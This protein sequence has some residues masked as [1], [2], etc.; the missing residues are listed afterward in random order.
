MFSRHRSQGASLNKVEFN[1]PV[2]LPLLLLITN[3]KR[4]GGEAL[5]AFLATKTAYPLTI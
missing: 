3:R 4:R 1:S 2:E 5:S